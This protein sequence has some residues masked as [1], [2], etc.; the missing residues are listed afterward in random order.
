MPSGE[1]ADKVLEATVAALT[2]KL[3]HAPS[4]TLQ[5]APKAPNAPICRPLPRDSFTSI[6]R[7]AARTGLRLARIPNLMKPSIRQKLDLLVDRFDE[8]DR[9]CR[10]RSTANDRTTSA[11]SS[12]NAPKWSR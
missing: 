12:A 1:A 8:I 7:V 4:Q 2:N 5:S 9:C 6:P 3:L 11:S 10:P